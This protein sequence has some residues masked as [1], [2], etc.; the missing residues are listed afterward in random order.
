MCMEIL[1]TVCSAAGHKML[2]YCAV[3]VLFRKWILFSALIITG[4]ENS[5]ASVNNQ[6]PKSTVVDR[7]YYNPNRCAPPV[8]YR[9]SFY[10][11][12]MR[13]CTY[14][15]PE[16]ELLGTVYCKISRH[17]QSCGTYMGHFKFHYENDCNPFLVV[18]KR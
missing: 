8:Q 15:K 9:L 6:I 12:T 7:R 16:P 1:A 11:R 5:I 14:V 13:Q 10:F 18:H 17:Y 2:N 4:I 3:A